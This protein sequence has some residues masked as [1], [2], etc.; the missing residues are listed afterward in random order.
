MK[1]LALGTLAAVLLVFFAVTYPK[2][3]WAEGG[4][5]SG[6]VK[7]AGSVTPKK[8]EVD[9]DQETCGKDK[10]DPSILA[11]GGKL[12]N[13]LVSVADVKGG[14]KA[15]AKDVTFDQKGCVF[16]PHVLL[17]A[18]GSTVNII[19]SDPITHNLHTFT[20]DNEPINKAQ[21]KTL[22]KMTA[23]VETPETIK[24]QCD[25]HKKWMSAWWIVT[26]NPYNAV[27]SKEGSFKITDVP[28]GTYK[29]TAWHETLGK[30][31]AD[32]TVKAGEDAK[33]N[34]EFQPKK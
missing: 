34:F 22:P 11:S 19:N 29:I 32:V 30:Q 4:S 21:P 14:K 16:M 13:V 26:D 17:V 8:I 15:E 1:K 10:D 3:V 33:V 27:S 2:M 12:G 25:I 9:K 24:V 28:P 6:E 23:K 31:T 18:A 20:V 5:I 7:V